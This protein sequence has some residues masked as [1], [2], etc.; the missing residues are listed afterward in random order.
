MCIIY[1]YDNNKLMNHII[2]ELNVNLINGPII[3]WF[4]FNVRFKIALIMHLYTYINFI[5]GWINELL[6][7]YEF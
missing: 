3:L 2:V 4:I 1:Y 7:I 6:W 5:L